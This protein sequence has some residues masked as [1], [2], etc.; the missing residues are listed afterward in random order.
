MR[1]KAIV[2]GAAI[3]LAAT[4]GSVT[5]DE[6]FSTL[7]GVSAELLS[8]AALATVRGADLALSTPGGGV[9]PFGFPSRGFGMPANEIV[10]DPTMDPVVEM[11]IAPPAL[12]H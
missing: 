5:A 6:Q 4:I 9:S 2:A 8:P 1:I 11:N 10:V 7:E 3:A 12:H